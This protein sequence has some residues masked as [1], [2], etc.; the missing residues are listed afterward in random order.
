MSGGAVINLKGELVGLT[1]MAS[2]PAGFDAMAGYAIPMDKITKR[3]IS[4]LTE[5][6][7]VEYGLLG[8][9][10]DDKGT[11][12]VSQIKHGSPAYLAQL[13]VNDQIVAVNGIPVTN[14]D[15]LI[16]AVNVFP[17]GEAVR[18]KIQRGDETIERT[19]V[20]AKL[21]IEGEVIATNRPK[22]WRGLRVEY[23]AHNRGSEPAMFGV[24]AAEVEDGSKAADSGL[25]RG[26]LIRRVAG[27][28]V[29][30]PREFGDAVAGLEGPVTLDTDLGQVTV[31]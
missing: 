1:T 9:Q 12:Y 24:V 14:F 23:T 19:I 25:K 11:N 18:L 8:I 31:K 16:L 3:A 30:S 7:E 20:L 27:K 10:A 17:A 22:P 15:S 13:Q 21:L 28:E 5:G 2:S 29:R 26:Q 6:K 4:S